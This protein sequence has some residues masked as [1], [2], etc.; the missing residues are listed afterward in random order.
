MARWV[1]HLDMDAFFASVEQLTRPTLRGR[2]VL[3]G[4]LG[5]RGVVAGASYESR[6]Y[7]A[8]SATT[9]LPAPGLGQVISVD[10]PA[11][12]LRC[13]L[14]V[15]G[16]I[17]VPPVLG[18]RSKTVVS[19]I[20]PAPVAAGDQLPVGPRPPTHPRVTLAP[21]PGAGRSPLR[22]LPGPQLD[23]LADPDALVT[24]AWRVD[25]ASDRV[26]MRLTGPPLVHVDPTRQLPSAGLVRGAIQ[27]PPSGLPVVFG[28]DHP[29]TGGYPVAG[30]LLDA[31]ADGG[32]QLRP[33]EQVRLRWA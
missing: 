30:V 3:V 12:G 22:M 24:T 27:V 11:G 1:L 17:D 7:G 14:A 20:G 2:P 16:G 13:Y 19:G 6:V 18:S 5:G 29:V 8:R 32:A 10:V 28:P 31:D 23:W 9:A 26:G 15:R 4:G 21:I 33:G 25:I